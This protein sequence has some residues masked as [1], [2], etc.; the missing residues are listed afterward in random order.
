MRKSSIK[1][2]KSNI[3]L[4]VA[5]A[6]RAGNVLSEY[7]EQNRK[8]LDPVH[9]MVWLEREAPELVAGAITAMDLEPG[10]AAEALKMVKAR[11]G[12]KTRAYWPRKGNLKRRGAEDAEG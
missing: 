6:P 5:P 8:W 4:R 11:L 1:P 7:L 10:P 2:P 9:V 3:V 12:R